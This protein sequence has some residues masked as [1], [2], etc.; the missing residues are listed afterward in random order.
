MSAVDGWVNDVD[1]VLSKAEANY[2]Q[3]TPETPTDEK[4][5]LLVDSRRLVRSILKRLMLDERGK[6]QSRRSLNSN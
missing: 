3:I 4:R 2:R 1:E 6:G 5:I